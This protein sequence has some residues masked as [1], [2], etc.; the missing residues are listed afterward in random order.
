MSAV[1]I[2]IRPRDFRPG[3]VLASGSVIV[4]FDRFG[5]GGLHYVV[6]S[7]A[8]TEYRIAFDGRRRYAV[9]R[10]VTA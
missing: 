4:G 10:E 7:L 1:E 2:K 5:Y 3:D 8:G 6:R 9:T